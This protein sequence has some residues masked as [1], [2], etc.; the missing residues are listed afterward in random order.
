MP[1]Q[2]SFMVLPGEKFFQGHFD[3][4]PVLPA[5]A[6]FSLVADALRQWDPTAQIIGIEAARFRA[7][8]LPR[9]EL[10]VSFQG[11]SGEDKLRFDIHRDEQVISQGKIHVSRSV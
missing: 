6:Q 10:K 11:Q 5:V 1:D 9:E 7:L 4:D 2:P 3:G 8:V